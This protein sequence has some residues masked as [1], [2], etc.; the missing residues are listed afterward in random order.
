[1]AIS[2]GFVGELASIVQ[3]AP[4]L[5][6]VCWKNPFGGTRKHMLLPVDPKHAAQWGVSNQ[7]AHK[8]N[9]CSHEHVH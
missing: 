5:E 7:I 4:C 3:T 1:M 8:T 9:E 2:W 6:G